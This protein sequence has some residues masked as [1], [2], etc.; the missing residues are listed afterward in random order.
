MASDLLDMSFELTKGYLHQNEISKDDLPDFI[1]SIHRTLSDLRDSGLATVTP[2][3]STAPALAAPAAPAAAALP[4]PVESAASAPAAEAAA[5]KRRG[6]KPGFKRAAAEKAA[7][8]APKKEE[9]KAAPE[10]ELSVVAAIRDEDISDPR[11]KGIDPWL[12]MRISPTF[13]EKLNPKN[14]IHPTIFEDKLIC[15]EDGSEVKLLRSYVKKNF[16]LDFHQYMSKWNLPS[17]YPT[18]PAEYLN[19]KRDIAK[20]TG[21]GVTTRAHRENRAAAAPAATPVKVAKAKPGP[22]AGTRRTKKEIQAAEA[23]TA[24]AVS[25]RGARRQISLFDGKGAKAD[26][27]EKAA[28]PSMAS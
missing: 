24:K 2:A 11:Y 9:L 3:A 5:P 20:K 19:K 13:A 25:A 1:R 8:A 12:A 22:K 16:G 7:A 14:K 4:A 6:P 10:P 17:D 21:L 28:E 27:A 15:L 18:A 23:S 26:A